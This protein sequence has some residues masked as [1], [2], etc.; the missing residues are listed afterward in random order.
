V[1]AE[2][3]EHEDKTETRKQK[4]Q[5]TR[6]QV[7]GNRWRQRGKNHFIEKL[8]AN[9]YEPGGFPGVGVKRRDDVIIAHPKK[10]AVRVSYSSREKFPYGQRGACIHAETD[11]KPRKNKQNNLNTYLLL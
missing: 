4:A 10:T 5:G 6:L 9:R 11:H 3:E 2:K 7:L 8:G 1:R